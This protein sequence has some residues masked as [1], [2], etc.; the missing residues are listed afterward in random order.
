MERFTIHW[1]PVSRAEGTALFAL[2]P[3]PVNDDAC[4]RAAGFMDF[5]DADENW[6]ADA[7]RLLT[8]LLAVLNSYGP[9]RL[10]SRPVEKHVPWYRRPFAKSEVFDLR[11]QIELPIQWDELPDC[12]VSFGGSGV[13]LR[14]GRGHHIFWITLP[15]SEAGSFPALVDRVAASHPIA[16]TDL[17]WECLV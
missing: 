16:R 4:F 7:G 13:S 14:T 5:G 11:Q 3:S 10:L 12:T 6:D 9:P 17:K 8:G 2:W 15:E 1:S